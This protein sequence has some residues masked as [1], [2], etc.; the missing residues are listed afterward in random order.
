MKA[1][2]LKNKPEPGNHLIEASAGTGKTYSISNLFLHFVLQGNP[3]QSILVVTFTEAATKELLERIRENLLKAKKVLLQLESDETLQAIV[4]QY[5]QAAFNLNKALLNFD[6]ASVFTIHGFCQRMLREYA[7]E[8]S[9]MFGTELLKEDKK[10]LEEVIN[11]FWRQ[12][13]YPLNEVQSNY[14]DLK[15]EELLQ[16]G[17][18]LMQ[19]PEL[20]FS[21][22]MDELIWQELLKEHDVLMSKCAEVLN[23]FEK[24]KDMIKDRLYQGALSGNIYK[25]EQFEDKFEQLRVCLSTGLLDKKIIEY[26]GENV[27]AKCKK[28]EL[29]PRHECFDQCKALSKQKW[30]DMKRGFSLYLK[31]KLK[32]VL[33]LKL[34]KIKERWEVMLFSDLISGLHAALKSEGEKGALHQKIR[35]KYQVV[36]VDEFQDTDPQQFEI[37]NSVF[38]QSRE[39]AFY[40]IGDPKQSIYAFRG[41]DVLAYL[42][43]KHQAVQHTLDT[44]YRSEKGMVDAVNHFFN[45]KDPQDAFAHPPTDR[46]EGIVFEAVASGARKRKLVMPDHHALELCWFEDPKSDRGFSKSNVVHDFTKKVCVDISELL[47]ASI[48]GAAYFENPDNLERE[49]IK[50]GDIAVLVQ[51]HSEAILLKNELIQL[52]IPSVISKSGNIFDT[53]EAKDVLRLLMA[54]REPNH[55][56]IMSLWLSHFFDDDFYDIQ[57]EIDQ[58]S[59][60]FLKQLCEYQ[61]SWPRLGVLQV[62]Q[63][64]MHDHDVEKRLLS[65]PGGERALSNLLQCREILHEVE[66]EKGSSLDQLIQFLN[67]KIHSESKDDEKYLQRLETDSEAVQIMT[68]F[69]SKG[70][71][72]PI[73]FCPY[74]W[75]RSF[76]ESPQT[77]NKDFSFYKQEESE[78]Q[79]QLCMNPSSDSREKY[80]RQWRLEK[81]GEDLR[82]L[83]V[84]LTRSV[85]KCY[86]YWGNIQNNPNALSYLATSQLKSEDLLLKEKEDYGFDI[87]KDRGFWQNDLASHPNIGFSTFYQASSPAFLQ[88]GELSGQLQTPADSPRVDQ[89]WMIGSFTALSKSIQQ[90][91]YELEDVKIQNDDDELDGVENGTGPVQF[92]LNFPRGAV[93]GSVVHEILENIHFQDRSTWESVVVRILRKYRFIESLEDSQSLGMVQGC[94]EMLGNLCHANLLMSQNGH[95]VLGEIFPDSRMDEM[96]FY[97]PCQKI[98][99]VALQELFKKHYAGDQT[100]ADYVIDLQSLQFKMKTGY[101]TGYVDCV[102]ES[103]GQYFLIDWKSNYLGEQIQAYAPEKLKTQIIHSK[104][105]LQ[106]HIYSL[107]LHELLKQRLKSEYDYKR[108]FGGVL[109]V[110]LRGIEPGKNTGVY[111]EKLPLGLIEDMSRMMIGESS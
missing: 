28:G 25:A 110:F 55:K 33:P 91:S 26:F 94:L 9:S 105:Y 24:N 68:V 3:V 95:L 90:V 50:P 104:Y 108:D 5:T 45:F 64:F 59:L 1:L 12:E 85:N 43:A 84:A 78:I 66:N 72:F 8:S 86:L 10:I 74:L 107:A 83:Y 93:A 88:E 7:F 106:F 75:Q 15:R 103:G 82:L 35:E 73:V 46:T 31:N 76:C 100:K 54:I 2:Q 77:K 13:V 17:N 51:K 18:Q 98:G 37:F 96:E 101:L 16:L 38:G 63:K 4:S 22:K 58:R 6:Q 36:L 48:K 29:P 92:F 39:H 81:L 14:F 47:Q 11:D 70:L 69:K 71:E 111:F 57:N 41:A 53:V 65:R 21:D 102:V 19:N 89:S 109:Y 56:N 62:L 49:K 44:N 99:V 67:E 40:M 27:E 30:P 23:L 34:E 79:R 61:M 52:G 97:Y 20:E 32:E 60:D 87:Q 80:R 42:K